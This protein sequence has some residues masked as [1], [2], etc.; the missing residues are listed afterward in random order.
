MSPVTPAS[1]HMPGCACIGI[2]EPKNPLLLNVCVMARF[3]QLG[4]IPDSAP[5]IATWIF[6][7]IV[8][9]KIAIVM[10][11]RVPIYKTPPLSE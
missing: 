5:K 6:I 3:N 8:R 1:P 9:T 7:G 2:N 11:I 4:M 10:S